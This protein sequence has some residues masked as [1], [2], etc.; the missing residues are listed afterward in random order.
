MLEQIEVKKLS[1]LIAIILGND[2]YTVHLDFNRLKFKFTVKILDL[3][4]RSNFRRSFTI[5]Y[6]HNYCSNSELFNRYHENVRVI[7]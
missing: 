1:K 5:N 4:I 7:K 3:G 6:N 2:Y